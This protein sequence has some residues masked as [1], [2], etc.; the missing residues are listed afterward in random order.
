MQC[1]YNPGA[2]GYDSVVPA[3]VDCIE[4]FAELPTLWGAIYRGELVNFWEVESSWSAFAGSPTYDPGWRQSSSFWPHVRRHALE[5]IDAM[6]AELNKISTSL[7]WTTATQD[8]R[9]NAADQAFILSWHNAR[10]DIEGPLHSAESSLS[11]AFSE[12][13][14]AIDEAERPERYLGLE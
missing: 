11:L 3:V 6:R 4:H 8:Y 13:Y 10:P 2:A 14:L 7:L 9:T 12:W 5:L 1:I